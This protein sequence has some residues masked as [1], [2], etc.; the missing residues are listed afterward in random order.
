MDT[1]KRIRLKIEKDSLHLQRT[2]ETGRNYDIIW[3]TGRL[4][5]SETMGI[6]KKTAYS[7]IKSGRSESKQREGK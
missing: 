5:L 6:K 2:Q 7:W 1:K 4:V 3:E